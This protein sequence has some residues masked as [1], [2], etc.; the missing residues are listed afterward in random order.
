MKKRVFTSLALALVL[1]A[2]LA[3]AAIASDLTDIGYL[4]QSAL[5]SLPAFLSANEQLAAYKQQLDQQFAV[6]MRGAKTDADKQ[7]I[8]MQFQ[9]EFSD[10]QNVL[11]GPL[12]QRAQLAIADVAAAR[13]LSIVVDKRIVIYGG[14]DITKDVVSDVRGSQALAPPPGTPPPSVIGFVDQSALANAA[15]VKSASE[16]LQKFQQQQQPIYAAKFKAA[17]N[18]VDKQQVMADYNKTIQDE[19]DKL[20]KPLV[21]E[22]KSA[23][24]AVARKKNLLLVIDRADVVFGGT[25][26]TQDVQN[27]LGK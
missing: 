15:A 2:A 22:T 23:T 25:D 16:K 18:D 5:A 1:G 26:I 7:R 9:Q 19:Q 10:K 3:P 20:L 8:T 4:D 14:Q 27:A 12:Y 13:K 21:S 11:L 17:K 24:A 6:A